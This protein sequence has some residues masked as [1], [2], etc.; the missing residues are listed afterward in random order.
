MLKRSIA[1]TL[2][3]VITLLAFVVVLAMAGLFRVSLQHGFR[4]YVQSLELARLGPLETQLLA[5]YAEQGSWDF[6]RG[7]EDIGHALRPPPPRWSGGWQGGPPGDGY[8]PPPGEGRFGFAQDTSLPP[9]ESGADGMP[10]HESIAGGAPSGGAGDRAPQ[11]GGRFG[12]PTG[13]GGG[14]SGGPSGRRQDILSLGPRAALLDAEGN[15]LAGNRA[16]LPEP[17]RALYSGEGKARRLVGHLILTTPPAAQR[18][19]G[20]EFVASQLKNLAWISLLVLVL[21]ALA[22]LGLARY[23]RRP[24]SAL[25][26]GARRIARGDLA[27]RLPAT[28]GDELGKLAG[29]FNHMAARLETMEQSRRQWVADTSHELRTP[30]TVLATHLEAMRDGVIP[31]TPEKLQVLARTVD[32]M[33][34]LVSDLHQLATADAGAQDYRYEDVSVA[35]LLA[36]LETTFAPRCA[37]AGLSFSCHDASAPGSTVRADHLR[38]SQVLGNLLTNSC[39][40]TDAPGEIRLTAAAQQDQVEFVV[41]DSAPGVPAVALPKLFERF[42]R[43]DASRSRQSGGSGL[44]LSICRAIVQAHGGTISAGPS[45]LGGLRVSVRLPRTLEKKVP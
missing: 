33:N 11:G 17:R 16:A 26:E 42:Y 21:S 32:D 28:R 29:D 25:A 7:A 4:T 12:P 39:R 24:L 10:P 9:R 20:E 3:L 30:I 27:A 40:Y 38:L 35:G 13:P 22:A 34:R 43:V 36:E 37:K 2:F 6:I 31:V 19:A 45:S 41:E 44:G 1:Q 18:Q 14:S 15:F 23:F 5:R 8:G